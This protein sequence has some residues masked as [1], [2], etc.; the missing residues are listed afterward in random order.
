MC[1]LFRFYHKLA[2]PKN[3]QDDDNN[4]F[5]SYDFHH[6]GLRCPVDQDVEKANC[7]KL[8][9]EGYLRATLFHGIFYIVPSD[10]ADD[11]SIKVPGTVP[12]TKFSS[13]KLIN[14]TGQ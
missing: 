10:Y 1:G 8:A 9:L 3:S 13:R 6:Y 4:A 12:S 14:P 7:M 11:D 5:N 2:V